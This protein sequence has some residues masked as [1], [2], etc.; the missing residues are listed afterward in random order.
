MPLKVTAIKLW[1]VSSVTLSL[2]MQAT[3]GLIKSGLGVANNGLT[4]AK[5]VKLSEGLALSL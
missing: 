2:A 5:Q 1:V 4:A 3:G